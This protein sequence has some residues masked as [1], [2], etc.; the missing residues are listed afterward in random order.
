M[1]YEI[2]IIGSIKQWNLI[3][4]IVVRNSLWYSHRLA[5]RGET[6]KHKRD[7]LVHREVGSLS[8]LTFLT[9]EYNGNVVAKCYCYSQI[10]NVCIQVMLS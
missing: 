1:K 2:S 9:L 3:K 10:Y 5:F 4:Y 8:V 7:H 6:E